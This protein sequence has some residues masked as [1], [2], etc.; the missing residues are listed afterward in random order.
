MIADGASVLPDGRFASVSRDRKLRIFDSD[1]SWDVIETPHENS[2]KAVA[3]DPASGL[4]ATAGYRGRV[5]VYDPGS[6]EWVWDRR[7]T[8][9]GISCISAT[10]EAGKFLASSYDGQVYEVNAAARAQ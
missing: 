9:S 2:H 1:G 6:G 4:V 3:V 5:A 7:L 10:A 8:M